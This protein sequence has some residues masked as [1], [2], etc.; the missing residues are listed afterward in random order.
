MLWK[1]TPPVRE[2]FW[3]FVDSSGGGD[4]L[5]EVDTGGGIEVL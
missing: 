5:E 2:L 4:A 1:A 3:K